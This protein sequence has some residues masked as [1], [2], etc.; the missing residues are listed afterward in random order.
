MSEHVDE[1]VPVKL[2]IRV[3]AGVLVVALEIKYLV[4]GVSL[5][6]DGVVD[7]YA[8]TISIAD[9]LTASVNI[10]TIARN[11][12]AS[13]LEVFMVRFPFLMLDFFVP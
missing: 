10:I 9:T 7:G 2:L 3:S 5:I 8:A 1:N 12:P 13:L 11:N 4:N 6:L